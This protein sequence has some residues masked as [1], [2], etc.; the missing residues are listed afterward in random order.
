GERASTDPAARRR[1]RPG[2]GRDQGRPP[3]DRSRRGDPGRR[4]KPHGHHPRGLRH[5]LPAPQAHRGG[6]LAAGRA[7][8]DPARRV[9][10]GPP[11]HGGRGALRLDCPVDPALPPDRGRADELT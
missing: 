2:D 4:R 10:Q 7:Q 1:K 5:D 9:G 8:D 3:S 6:L 11:R